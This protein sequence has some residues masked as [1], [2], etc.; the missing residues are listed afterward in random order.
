MMSGKP[1][2][3]AI[4]AGNNLVEEAKCGVY[5]E[6]GNIEDI[7]SA[8]LHLKNLNPSE[9]D[10]L[11][12]NGQNYVKANHSYD[13]LTDKYLKVIESVVLNKN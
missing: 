11:G 3:Q 1:I 13:I 2:V 5:A 8:I 10:K 7:A 12:K 9:R 4:E 6:P